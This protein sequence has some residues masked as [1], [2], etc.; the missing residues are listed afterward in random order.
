MYETLPVY[1]T[2]CKTQGHSLRTCKKENQRRD[3]APKNLKDGEKVEKV[4]I[5]QS[6]DL[7]VEEIC[8]DIKNNMIAL[9]EGT[10]IVTK[11]LVRDEVVPTTLHANPPSELHIPLATLKDPLNE[12][13]KMLTAIDA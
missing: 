3:S 8:D 6:R 1:C 10:K 11:T 4:W 13:N 9:K 5:R 7:V 12:V 2:K